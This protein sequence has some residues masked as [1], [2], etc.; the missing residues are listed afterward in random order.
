MYIHRYRTIKY[1]IYN[2]IIIYI[3]MY[4]CMYKNLDDFAWLENGN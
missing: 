4:K 3:Y 2:Y 1:Y